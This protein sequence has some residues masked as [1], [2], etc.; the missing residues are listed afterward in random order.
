M[1]FLDNI[2]GADKNILLIGICKAS[3]NGH[4]AV[5]DTLSDKVYMSCNISIENAMLIGACKSGNIPLFEKAVAKGANAY[6]NAFQNA[7]YGGHRELAEKVEKLADWDGFFNS[8][9]V[10]FLQEAVCGGHLNSVK[11]VAS[12]IIE[13]NFPHRIEN[14]TLDYVLYK[15]CLNGHMD[16]VDF[17]IECG[18]SDW[19]RGL[20]Y[21]CRGGHLEIAKKIVQIKKHYPMN[22]SHFNSALSYAC[23]RGNMDV[24]HWLIQKGAND[25]TD[26]LNSAC[27]CGQVEVAKLMLEKGGRLQSYGVHN[28]RYYG[29]DDIIE[30]LIE[31]GEFER[32]VYKLDNF[33]KFSSQTS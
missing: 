23:Q 11:W 14:H 30:L 28:A 3:Q 13:N 21:A 5:I 19:Y 29:Y 2:Y 26:G 22:I 33:V 27:C 9:H 32:V 31:W 4:I 16:I 8:N 25:W 10:T 18:A 1:K 6:N 15:A 7:C 20:D 24:I 17:L 12:R